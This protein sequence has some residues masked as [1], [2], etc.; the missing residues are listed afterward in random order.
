M[1]ASVC[2]VCVCFNVCW[3]DTLICVRVLFDRDFLFFIVCWLVSVLMYLVVLC[4]VFYLSTNVL[5][6][7]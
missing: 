5:V 7:Q 6:T 4:V 2:V 1:C 3:R